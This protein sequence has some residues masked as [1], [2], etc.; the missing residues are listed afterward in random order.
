MLMNPL[1]RLIH[2]FCKFWRVRRSR[3]YWESLRNIHLG[4]RGFVI[5]NGPSLKMTDLD[6]LQGEITLAANKIY[7][8]FDETSWRPSHFT[9]CDDVLWEKIRDEMVS[10]FPSVS[11][12]W[13]YTSQPGI[14]H[15]HFQ[16]LPWDLEAPADGHAFSMN[17]ADG[18]FGGFTVTYANL[19]IAAHMGLEPIYL[20]GCDHHYKGESG[21]E[22]EDLMATVTDQNHFNA[23]YR[24]VGEWVN[25]APLAKMEKAFAHARVVHDQGRVQ[26]YNATR[27]GYLN[28]FERVGFDTL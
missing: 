12:P 1:A 6:Q 11:S 22:D 14:H 27:G 23:A 19:Q 16:H 20:L 17:V 25:A 3:P 13:D 18:L 9:V 26:I 7:L 28:I 21:A 24:Q 5:G 15:R 10:H 2:K 8:A 4:R